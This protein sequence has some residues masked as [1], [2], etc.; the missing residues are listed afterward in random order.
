M[1]TETNKTGL[2]DLW[3]RKVPQS[4]GT[5]LAVGFGLLQFLEFTTNRYDLGGH[6]VDKYLVVWIALVPAIAILAYYGSPLRPISSLNDLK[7]PKFIILTNLLVAIG[8]GI[9]LFNDSSS[10]ASEIVQMT[11]EDGNTVQ[12]VVPSLQKIKTIACFQFENQTGDREQDWW[13]VAFSNLLA[14]NLEQRPEFYTTAEFGLSGYYNGLGLPSFV[15]PNI[16]MQRE[17]ARKSRNDYFS[18]ISYTIE[19][20][21]FVFKGGLYNTR[22]G[23]SIFDIDISNADPY[24]A[25]DEIQEQIFNKIPNAFEPIENQVNLPSS[26]LFTSNTEALKYFTLSRIAY[27][28]N[29]TGLDEV[30]RLAKMAVEIDPACSLCHFFVGDPLYGQGKRDEAISYV[31]N[32]IKYGASLPERMQFRA[33]S[34]LYSI[35]NRQDA[36]LKLQE[37]RRKMFPFEFQA[38]Q[39]LVSIYKLNHGVDSAKALLQEAIE[40]GNLERGLLGMYNLQLENEEFTEA[41]KTLDQLNEAFPDREEDQL[42]YATIYEKQGR[43]EEAKKILVEQETMD[44]LNMRIQTSLAYLDFKDLKIEEA[45]RRV[46]Q[47]IEQSTTLVDSLNFLWIKMF[48]AQKTGQ[49]QKAFSAL[50]DHKKQQLK[51]APINRLVVTYFTTK[52]DMYLSTGQA[53]RINELLTELAKYSPESKV[54]YDCTANSQAL[55]YDYQMPMSEEEFINCRAAYGVYGNGATEYFDVLAYYLQ[56]DY[57]KCVEILAA[58][59][60]RIE[61]FLISGGLF[62]AK[63]YARAGDT[64][65]ALGLLQKLIDQKTDDPMVYYQ[66]ASILADEDAE[67]AKE[68]LGIALQFW[69]KADA[70]Y[71]P[72]Q[73]AKELAQ[74]LGL[75]AS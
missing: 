12:A 62:L 56:E 28:K 33:K 52:A 69:A 46:Q 41:E 57:K 3:E 6:W 14:F 22:D 58:D 75:A 40:Y 73:R 53:E 18:R 19:D 64:K 45:N 11:D 42:K 24:A 7:W 65:H 71:I 15:P 60:G 21:Q 30:V 1:N 54:I 2:E 50:D 63:V 29:P 17:I 9:F 36:Y 66:M 44:P 8:A 35:T 26:A 59:D 74:K 49:I 34:V 37:V 16:G 23:K 4:L 31:K 51:R 39:A 48:F 68:N 55:I 61:R 47:G 10:D 70:D 13:G 72:Y 67:A 25:I 5:Y 38:Y 32:A 27:Y 20:E 43:I